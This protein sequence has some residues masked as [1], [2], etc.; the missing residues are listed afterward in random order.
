MKNRILFTAILFC[1][2]GIYACKK[3]ASNTVVPTA[4]TISGHFRI[5]WKGTDYNYNFNAKDTFLGFTLS[6]S[7][8]QSDSGA[9]LFAGAL[10]FI[11]T[12]K[13]HVQLRMYTHKQD[14][15]TDTG[16]YRMGMVGV[17][18]HG[19]FE[20][21]DLSATGYYECDYS[22]SPSYVHVTSYTRGQQTNI[23][24][25]IHLEGINWFTADHQVITGDF[26]IT[27]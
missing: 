5:N 11:L 17:Y 7:Y 6:Q 8:L 1:L 27:R 14:E 12:D 9:I 22:P 10:N 21:R 26:D 24:G 23:K 20:F 2:L 16:M 18:D 4:D 25:D 13:A 19:N 3:Q 15:I